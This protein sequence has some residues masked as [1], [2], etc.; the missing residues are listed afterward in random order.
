MVN[1]TGNKAE[2]SR[3]TQSCFIE[4]TLDNWG[5]EKGQYFNVKTLRR[6]LEVL[7]D[8][9]FGDYGIRV[10]Y[11]CNCAYAGIRNNFNISNKTIQFQE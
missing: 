10:G 8:E 2:K 1:K 5:L 3:I 11:D 6:A 9:G 7:E 4:E